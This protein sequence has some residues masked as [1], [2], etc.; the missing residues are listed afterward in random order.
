[1]TK[2]QIDKYISWIDEGKSFAILREDLIKNGTAP[3]DVKIIL[4]TLDEINSQEKLKQ[5]DK[6]QGI[7]WIIA[8]TIISII[9]MAFFVKGFIVIGVLIALVPGVATI[10]FGVRKY[11]GN[12]ESRQTKWQGVSWIIFGAIAIIISLILFVS[13]SVVSL[14]IAYAIFSAGLSILFLGIKKY[15]ENPLPRIKNFKEGFK[16][17]TE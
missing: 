11:K 4:Q 13:G 14:F 3:E 9:S 6:R 2:A 7:Q 15:R 8:G 12:I 16:Q 10:I 17:R 1:M 5:I